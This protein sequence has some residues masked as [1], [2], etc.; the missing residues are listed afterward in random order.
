MKKTFF[1]IAASAVLLAGCGSDNNEFVF[2]DP[3]PANAQPAI[4]RQQVEFLARPGIAEGLLVSNELLQRYN[5]VGPSFVAAALADPNSSQAQA[6]GPIFEQALLVLNALED[7]DGQ[8]NGLTTDEIVGAFLPDVMRIDT[9]LPAPAAGDPAYPRFNPAGTTLAGGR[10]LTD[11]VIDITLTVL[12][13]GVVT[14]DG[15]PY[16]RPQ[17]GTGSTNVHIGHSFLNGQNTEYGPAEFP[18]LAEPQ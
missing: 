11:D 1:A 4:T 10:M 15:V 5:S 17:A 16:Y 13:D 12:T 6:A 7:L 3:Q 14:S 8:V 2:T 9:T 18:F